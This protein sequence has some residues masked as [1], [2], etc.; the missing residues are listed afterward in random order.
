MDA[1]HADA[2][3]SDTAK[4]SGKAYDEALASA[5]LVTPSGLRDEVFLFFRFSL[6]IA[7]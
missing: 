4:V 1:L 7:N 2:I 5:P 3:L 6:L